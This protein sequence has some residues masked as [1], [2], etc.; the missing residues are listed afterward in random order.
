MLF[1]LDSETAHRVSSD[2]Q[3]H[4]P[5]T[6]P[7]IAQSEPPAF[8]HV[9]ATGQEARLPLIGAIRTH[10]WSILL[11][12]GARFAENGFFFL[13][14]Q[15]LCAGLRYAQA[16]RCVVLGPY[17]CTPLYV[18][19]QARRT[20]KAKRCDI[21]R[22]LAFSYD[23]FPHYHPRHGVPIVTEQNPTNFRGSRAYPVFCSNATQT[24]NPN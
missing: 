12:I 18:A 20:E 3:R 15:R 4:P 2:E 23:P 13:C 24:P 9:K 7:R 5:V 8:N 19:G 1:P 17:K 16:E 11:A 21:S 14:V 22:F 10:P 6:Y